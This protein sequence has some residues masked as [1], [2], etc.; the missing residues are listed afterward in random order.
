MGL[1]SHSPQ[2]LEQYKC[3]CGVDMRRLFDVSESNA[4]PPVVGD[5]LVCEEC[6]RVYQVRPN[7]PALLS[8][9]ELQGLTPETRRR[10]TAVRAAALGMQ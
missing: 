2:H 6:T 5:V 9:S 7:G 3:Q 10:V 1:A 8:D 4:L